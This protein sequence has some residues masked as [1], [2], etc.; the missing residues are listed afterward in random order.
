MFY[1]ASKNKI[2]MEA[3]TQQNIIAFGTSIVGDI[4]SKG[5]FRIDGSVDGNVITEG[6]IVIG[7]AGVINGTLK[8]VN[9]DIE[10]R[11]SGKLTLS[12]TLILKSSAHIEGEV[13]VKKLAVEPGATFHAT[14]SMKDVLK[15]SQNEQPLVKP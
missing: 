3:S 12:G 11:F 5:P 2:N 10:G 1:S 8:A 7:K 13:V 4:T 9:A 14:C 6:K 15:P